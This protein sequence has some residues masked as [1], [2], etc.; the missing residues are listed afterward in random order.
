MIKRKYWMEVRPKDIR[1][2][3]N[4]TVPYWAS[5]MHEDIPW[6]LTILGIPTLVFLLSMTII[7]SPRVVP[8]D[9]CC[10]PTSVAPPFDL[11]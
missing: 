3:T 8:C 1:V 10:F 6:A 2:N 4:P 7:V 9:A 5:I 11:F